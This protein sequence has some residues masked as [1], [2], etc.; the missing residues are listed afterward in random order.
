MDAYLERLI[1]EKQQL[2]LKRQGLRSFIASEDFTK[3]DPVQMTL[4]NIQINAMDTYGQILLERIV[5][6]Q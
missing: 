2:D 4:L 6:L 5:R 1:E 3:I